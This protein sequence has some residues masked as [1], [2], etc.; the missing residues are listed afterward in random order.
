MIYNLNTAE[1]QEYFSRNDLV[2]LEVNAS[3]VCFKS[4]GG[5]GRTKSLL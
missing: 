5:V 3:N 4:L 2:E 1:L